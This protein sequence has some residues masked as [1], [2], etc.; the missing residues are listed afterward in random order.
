MKGPHLPHSPQASFD[1][2][3]INQA[4]AHGVV[5]NDQAAW[6]ILDPIVRRGRSETYAVLCTLAEAAAF[7]ARED[8]EPGGYFGLKVR[9]VVTGRTG[10]ADDIPPGARFAMQFFTARLNR[11]EETAYALF[12]A[13]HQTDPDGVAVGFRI[14]YGM[15]VTSLRAIRERKQEEKRHRE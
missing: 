13:L 9:D 5:G 3:Q 7:N 4:L 2:D 1:S 6:S 14:L 12:M 8:R 10:S 15:A 11:D